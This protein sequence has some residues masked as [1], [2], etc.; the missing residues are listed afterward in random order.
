M[1]LMSIHRFQSVMLL[2]V[3]QA[4]TRVELKV[5]QVTYLPNFPR[6]RACACC[7]KQMVKFWQDLEYEL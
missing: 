6:K 3:Y 5:S 7:V 4:N 2:Y 1:K